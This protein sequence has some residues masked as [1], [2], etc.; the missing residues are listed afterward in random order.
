MIEMKVK[1]SDDDMT[2]T[3]KHLIYEKN[4]VLSHE[5]EVLQKLVNQSIAKFKGTPSDVLL[6]FKYVW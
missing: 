2:L 1:I 4:I 5:D 3:D 6:T